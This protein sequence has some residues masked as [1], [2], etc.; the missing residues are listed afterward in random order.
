MRRI[1]LIT[2]LVVLFLSGTTEA[3]LSSSG[4]VW[5]GLHYSPYAFSHDNPSGLVWKELRYNPYAF[6]SKHPYWPVYGYYG[7]PFAAH[8]CV[9]HPVV[10][11]AVSSLDVQ[12][13]GDY[14]MRTNR[15][16]TARMSEQEAEKRRVLRENDGKEIIRKHLTERRVAFTMNN[17]FFVSDRTLGIDFLLGDNTVIRYWNPEVIKEAEKESGWKKALYEKYKRDWTEFCTEHKTERRIFEIKHR[18]KKEITD[19]LEA[20]LAVE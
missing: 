13:S 11:G 10:V 9:S 17:G 6:G 18:N 8:Y 12:T 19:R 15:R 7:Y 5:K 2:L 1:I 16:C 14:E 3:R 20:I 4:L